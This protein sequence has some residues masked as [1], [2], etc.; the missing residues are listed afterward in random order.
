[1]I[2]EYS[3]WCFDTWAQNEAHNRLKTDGAM[4]TLPP[5]AIGLQKD[6]SSKHKLRTGRFQSLTE[7]RSMPSFSTEGYQAYSHIPH[8]PNKLLL[9]RYYF[10]SLDVTQDPTQARHNARTVLKKVKQDHPNVNIAIEISDG[11]CQ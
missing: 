1:M 7:S 3:A 8:A 6:F 4:N 5:N 11:G 10:L 2:I 9:T